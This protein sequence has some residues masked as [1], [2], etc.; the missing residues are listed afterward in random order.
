MACCQWRSRRWC[1]AE[2][3]DILPEVTRCDSSVVAQARGASV[4][5]VDE[6]GNT[7]LHVAAMG[8][9]VDILRQLVDQGADVQAIND[10]FETPLHVAARS[11]ST[12]T[13]HAIVK[14]GASV[15]FI[16]VSSCPK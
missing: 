8:A 3:P 5:A 6:A 12:Q 13:L 9:R 11:H 16:F 4:M 10:A 1:G 14:K 15:G 2:A 7:P